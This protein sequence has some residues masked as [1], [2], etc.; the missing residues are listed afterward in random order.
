MT[1]KLLFCLSI[2][3]N[4]AFSSK[5]AYKDKKSLLRVLVIYRYKLL[6]RYYFMSRQ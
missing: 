6:N 1:R 3:F 5:H 4:T 2:K